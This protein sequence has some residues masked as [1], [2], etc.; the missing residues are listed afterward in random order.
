MEDLTAAQA[1]AKCSQSLAASRNR[2][3]YV[4]ERRR[5]RIRTRLLASPAAAV[6]L[7]LIGSQLFKTEGLPAWPLLLVGVV[8]VVPFLATFGME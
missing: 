3:A 6:G 8:F 1:G 4:E 2:R 5:A 7:I